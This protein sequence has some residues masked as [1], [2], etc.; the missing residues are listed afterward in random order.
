MSA[1][2][3]ATL[4]LALCF[5]SAARADDDE[6]PPPDRWEAMPDA[7]EI[8]AG[9]GTPVGYLGL[10]YDRV[11]WSRWSANVGFG[12]GSG[13]EGGS[14]H[15]ATG[16]RFRVFQDRGGALYLGADYSTGGFRYVG[17]DVTPGFPH[18]GGGTERVIFSERVHWLQGSIGIESR[19]ASGAVFRPYLG[20]AIMLNPDSRRCVDEQSGR[21]CTTSFRD[22]AGD[23]I[24]VLGLA[25][26]GAR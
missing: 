19:S 18:S 1:L 15:L 3:L 12:V 24:A 8:H 21:S 25:I 26:G 13:R 23:S 5:A 17:I 7:L 22:Y 4:T 20:L 6:A 11:L 10:A 16:T 2:R 14:L 9:L